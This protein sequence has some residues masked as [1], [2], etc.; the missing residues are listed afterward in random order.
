LVNEDL[1]NEDA[2]HRLGRGGEE[3]PAPVPVARLDAADQ[4]EI[5][6]V[7]QGGGLERLARLLLRQARRREF[8][9]LVVDQR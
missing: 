9:Q 2:A 3:V 8:P 6:L 5:G 4:P 1:V 7:N